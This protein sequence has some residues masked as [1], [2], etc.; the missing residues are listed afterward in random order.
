MLEIKNLQKGYNNKPVIHDINIS[1]KRGEIHGLIGANGAGKTTLL[2]CAAGIYEAAKGTVQYDEEDIYDNPEVK[3]KV[4]YVSEQLDFINLYSV[5]GLAGYYRN[6]YDTFSM[7]KFED[8]VKRFGLNPKKSI[9]SLSKGQRAKLNFI[10]AVAQQPEY[11]IM[12]E[13]ESGMDAEGKSLFRDIL[14]EEVEQGKIGVLF[15]SH[16]LTDIEKICDSVAMIESGEVFAEK[17]VDE[18]MQ[19]IQKWRGIIPQTAVYEKPSVVIIHE[20]Y[21]IGDLSE[22]Y[23]VGNRNDNE[24]TLKKLD[25]TEYSAQQITLEEIYT[26]LKKIH[27]QGKGRACEK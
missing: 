15:S 26:L 5:S 22:F 25:I 11:I 6:F 3:K 19:G 27:I 23:T 20:N 13:P 24:R 10:L 12:D 4:A 14:I 16:D 21:K 8:L 18:L 1:V 17:S 7:E 9:G 2:K